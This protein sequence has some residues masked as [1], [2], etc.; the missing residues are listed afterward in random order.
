[1]HNMVCS[2]P[3]ALLCSVWP[4]LHAFKFFEFQSPLQ[5]F[6]DAWILTQAL[7]MLNPKN[8][9][10]PYFPAMAP[11]SDEVL[12]LHCTP[13]SAHKPWLKQSWYY[14]SCV[15]GWFLAFCFQDPPRLEICPPPPS[16]SQNGAGSLSQDQTSPLKFQPSSKS[17][18]V[19][20][21]YPVVCFPPNQAW[22]W[23]LYTVSL[24]CFV[25]FFV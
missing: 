15:D 12:E 16:L 21:T 17:P 9:K 10:R 5:H 24:F 8:R 4:S 1:M 7:Q 2:R 20:R 19:Q 13:F 14:C 3:P 18:Y 23:S 22:F 25:L 11:S 6:P